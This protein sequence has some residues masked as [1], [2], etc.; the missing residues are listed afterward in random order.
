MPEMAA[1]IQQP[2]R[3]PAEDRVKGMLMDT[4]EHAYHPIMDGEGEG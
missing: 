3:W 2:R 4:S 1:C